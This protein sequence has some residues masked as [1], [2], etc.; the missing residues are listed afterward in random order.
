MKHRSALS[1]FLLVIAVIAGCATS[2]PLQPAKGGDQEPMYGGMDRQSVPAL[3]TADEKLIA[4]ASKEFGSREK[5]S[6][7][8]VDQGIRL[9]QADNL[10]LAMKRLNQAWILNPSNPNVFWGF[11]MI[12]HDQGENCKAKDMIDRSVGLNLSKPIALA[13]AGR[14]YTLCGASD[15]ALD[16]KTRSGYFEKSEE[17]YKKASAAS[18][19]NGYIYGSWATAYYWRGDYA[20]SWEM[21]KKAKSTGFRF[22]EQFMNLLRDKMPEPK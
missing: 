19:N 13:D 18:Q 10:S 1:F 16:A 17:L 20:H 4:G 8:F 2:A 9:Y 7:A 15:K 14:I 11:A 6:D 12:Y 3:R 5:G 21:V 22:P